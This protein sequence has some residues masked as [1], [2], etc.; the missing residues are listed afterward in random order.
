MLGQ[1]PLCYDIVLSVVADSTVPLKWP[2]QLITIIKIGAVVGTK[3]DGLQLDSSPVL[4]RNRE[5]VV[6]LAL[7]SSDGFK[8]KPEG[9]ENEIPKIQGS[10]SPRFCGASGENTDNILV[11]ESTVTVTC[12]ADIF[13]AMVK[14]NASAK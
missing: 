11:L 14:F 2:V 1:P 9:S 8:A 3:G 7:A 13:R 5:P 12:V 6:I 10:T 4:R